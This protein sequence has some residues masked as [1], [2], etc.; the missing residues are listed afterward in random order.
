MDLL[1][2]VQLQLTIYYFLASDT[3]SQLKKKNE[4]GTS[5]AAMFSHYTV[6]EIKHKCYQYFFLQVMEMQPVSFSLTQ[7]I[8]LK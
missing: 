2:L 4:L 7:S 3:N 1:A 8:N 5:S 6:I